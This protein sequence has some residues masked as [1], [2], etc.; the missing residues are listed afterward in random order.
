MYN[1]ASLMLTGRAAF[2]QLQPALRKSRA[3]HDCAS[4]QTR[5]MQR[6][7]ACSLQTEIENSVAPTKVQTNVLGTTNPEALGSAHVYSYGR[8]P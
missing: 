5:R 8:A 6:E 4:S 1:S 3:M 7:N 2:A